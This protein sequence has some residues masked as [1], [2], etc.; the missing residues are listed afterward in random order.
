MHRKFGPFLRYAPSGQTE[1]LILVLR[2]KIGTRV[3]DFGR[4]GSP[5][6][7]SYAEF[8]SVWGLTVV[9]LIAFSA[10]EQY[11]CQVNLDLHSQIIRRIFSQH[12]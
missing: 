6:S 10:N 9:F 8:D 3:N 5:V 11:F 4:V 7:I 12:S 1:T 2:T